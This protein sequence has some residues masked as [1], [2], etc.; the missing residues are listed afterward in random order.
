MG[1]LFF[2]TKLQK[3]VSEELRIFCLHEPLWKVITCPKMVMGFENWLELAT[4]LGKKKLHWFWLKPGE[5]WKMWFKSQVKTSPTHKRAIIVYKWLQPF[6]LVQTSK[7]LTKNA[8]ENGCKVTTIQ[9]QTWNQVF[10]AIAYAFQVLPYLALIFSRLSFY[11][12]RFRIQQK[13][14]W[15]SASK[16]SNFTYKL[17]VLVLKNVWKNCPSSRIRTSDLRITATFLYSPP[18]YQLS[19]RG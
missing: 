13:M 19:Y 16:K 12:L 15:K 7:V 5:K 18:L 3:S 14:A 8:K 4:G 2:V 6:V 17:D 10:H 9:I 1:Y 11:G